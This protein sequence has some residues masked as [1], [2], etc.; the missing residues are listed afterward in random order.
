M[1][2]WIDRNVCESNL[3]ACE[4]CFG[5]FVITGVPDRPCILAY[6]DDASET[7]I[8][9]LHSEDHEEMLIIPAEMRELVAYDGWTKFVS[10]EPRFRKNEGTERKE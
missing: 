8:I 6:R 3:A 1:K 5:Q 10:F 2:V 9:F 7:L 4:S